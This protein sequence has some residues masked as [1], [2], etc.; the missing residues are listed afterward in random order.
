MPTI[1]NFAE[2]RKALRP[3]YDAYKTMEANEIYTLDRIKALLKHLENPQDTLKVVHVAGTSG[4]TSTA[5]YAAA[6]LEV[7]GAKVGLSA[8]PHVVEMNERVQIN[9]TP[10]PE[11][12]YCEHLGEFMDVVAETGIK[13][14]YFEL[15]VAFMFTEFARRKVDYAVVEVGMGGLVDGTNVVSR[16][17]K[18][19]IITDIGF[20]HTNFLGNTLAKIT[21]QKAGI[22]RPHNQAFMYTQPHEVMKVA[23]AAAERA[24]GT[25]HEITPENEPAIKDLHLPLFQQRNF[26]LAEQAANFVLERDGRKLLTPAQISEAAA[27][28]IPGRMEI[29]HNNGKTIVIDGAHNEQKMETLVRSVRAQFPN[30][31]IAALVAFSMAGPNRWQPALNALK[32]IVKHMVVSSF[33]LQPDDRLK[34]SVDAHELAD[35]L[36]TTGFESVAVEPEL[37]KAY[38]SLLQRPEPVL[39]VTG[40]LYMLGEILPLLR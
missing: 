32:P 15:K 10:L 27:T 38:A 18:V 14:S 23:R 25:L 1:R 7:S 21:A 37:T 8:S 3:F 31:P 6:L 36:K 40:S 30:R 4:K 12:E 24:E 11:A 26:Y 9:R 16:E 2:A 39:L 20:D 5:Y 34:T 19:C 17:D 35:Y 28:H 29:F 13:V 33:D 22:I